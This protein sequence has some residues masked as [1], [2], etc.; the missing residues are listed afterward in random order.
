MTNVEEAGFDAS[1]QCTFAYTGSIDPL[2]LLED[3]FLKIV[4][5]VLKGMRGAGFMDDFFLYILIGWNMR[6]VSGLTLAKPYDLV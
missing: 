2:V 1:A 5:K 6:I 4:R 3:T